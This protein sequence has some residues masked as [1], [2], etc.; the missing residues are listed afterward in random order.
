MYTCV[1]VDEDERAVVEQQW[2][3]INVGLLGDGQTVALDRKVLV[4]G[5]W[6]TEA[7]RRCDIQPKLQAA[8]ERVMRA[9]VWWAYLARWGQRQSG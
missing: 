8:E 3:W 4:R 5:P 7:L 1:A 2:R 9:R 6:A